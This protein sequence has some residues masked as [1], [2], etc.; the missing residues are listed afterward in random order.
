MHKVL[1]SAAV[2]VL[3]LACQGAH[4]GLFVP[5]ST[6]QVEANSSPDTFT[7]TVTLTPGVVQSLDGGAVDLRN[8]LVL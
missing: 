3:A 4:A 2:F 7:D 6:F 5:D 8:A 1:G